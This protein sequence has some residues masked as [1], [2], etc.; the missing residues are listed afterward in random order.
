[1]YHVYL[2][3]PIKG[4]TYEEAVAWRDWATDRLEDAPDIK[5]LS[6]MRGKECMRGQIINSTYPQSPGAVMARDHFDIA[7]CDLVLV[8]F[9]GVDEVS[10][11]TVMEIAW[12][13]AFHKPIV[14][15]IEEGNVHNHPM[16]RACCPFCCESLLAGIMLA[17]EVLGV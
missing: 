1:M 9:L 7:R 15:V 16:I 3:G 13:L 17:K 5:V 6:P 4:Q 12:A 2:A 10:I 14:L 11:G 8:N